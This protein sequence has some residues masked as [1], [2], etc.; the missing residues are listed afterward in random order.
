MATD[1][2]ID[3]I[4]R[5]KA[6]ES[7]FAELKQAD[8]TN[9][10]SIADALRI[11]V[12]E[13]HEELLRGGTD[14]E[15]IRFLL[16]REAVEIKAQASAFL[17][18][19]REMA[20][21][22]AALLRFAL[23]TTESFFEM[24]GD[25]LG[26]YFQAKSHAIVNDVERAASWYTGLT[27]TARKGG[28]IL[29]LG[30]RALK[31]GA[32]YA[33]G[34]LPEEQGKT[35]EYVKKGLD[36]VR[37]TPE[38][39]IDTRDVV[40]QAIERHIPQE[41]LIED[42]QKIL[43]EAGRRYQEAWEKQ[44]RAQTPDL[45]SLQA[46]AA[47]AGGRLPEWT[48]FELGAAEHTLAIGLG[49]AAVGALSLAAGWHVLAYA[50]VNVFYPVAIAA[51]LASLGVAFLTKEKTKENR[52]K[53]VNE[54]IEQCHRHF[55]VQIDLGKPDGLE[56]KTLRQAIAEQTERVIVQTLESWRRA[57]SGNL[58]MDHYRRLN[59]ACTH[60]LQL[61]QDCMATLPSSQHDS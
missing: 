4:A 35:S 40:R 19:E 14:T 3:Q 38:E 37:E 30:A 12:Q 26:G 6:F 25:A 47:G 54:A 1:D 46:F 24:V 43:T 61:I 51:A 53:K 27:D 60:H 16:F 10:A 55:L 17:N 42:V 34:L 41:T 20:S 49:G 5:L 29:N 33:S 52:K 59:A 45:S 56:G 7:V 36:Y 8:A 44:I 22:E 48:T 23:G 15:R 13:G 21:R 2:L 18:Y 28:V 31:K 39:V 58:T 9:G 32:D 57:I 11:C 50:M